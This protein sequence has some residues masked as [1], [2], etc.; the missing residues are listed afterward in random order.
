MSKQN[1]PQRL[2]AVVALLISACLATSASAS[3]AP[4]QRAPGSE[5]GKLVLVMDSSGSMAEKAAGGETKIVAAKK[6]LYTVIGGLPP[7]QPV[8][9]RVFG[10][11]VPSRSKPGACTDSQLKVPVGTGNHARLVAALGAYKPFGETPIGYALQQAG[12]DVGSAGRRSILLVSDGE[13]TCKPD[14]CT[15]ARELAKQGIDLE[16]DV[17]GLDVNSAARSKLQCIAHAGH[18]VYYDVDNSKDLVKSVEKVATRAARPYEEIGK[19]VNGGNTSITPAPIGNGDWLDH[20]NGHE[21]RYYK[22]TRTRKNSTVHFSAVIRSPDGDPSNTI[23]LST[24]DGQQCDASAGLTQEPYQL[25]STAV[26]AGPLDAVGDVV[27]PDDPCLTADTML[28][29]VHSSEEMAGVPIEIRVLELPEVRNIDALPEPVKKP[30]WTAPPMSSTP[31]QVRGGTSFNDA[32]TLTPGSYTDDIV[33]GETLTYRVHLDWGQQINAKATFAELDDA[34]R[35]AAFG[36]PLARIEAFSP[37]RVPASS[38][39]GGDDNAQAAFFGH[40]GTHLATTSG[41]VNFRNS[42]ASDNGIAG[43]DVDGTYTVVVFLSKE[44]S[45]QSVPVPFQLDLSV[46]GAKS[47]VPDFATAPTPP[48]GQPS[49]APPPSSTATPSSR[50]SASPL[51]STGASDDGGFPTGPVLGGLGALALLAAAGLVWQ[52]RS[53]TVPG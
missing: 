25:L 49:T 37:A 42:G 22:I 9:L 52:R 18:G 40:S 7:T 48:Q 26:L 16:I 51:A 12:K 24:A 6:A 41:P 27:S 3:T 23:S 46:L 5:T 1:F 47:G 11:T 17:V 8:G 50:P 28:A 38:E 43:A 13:P 19:P 4:P 33:Q 31:K 39:E 32:P 45:G 20:T 44:P 2:A 35:G 53:G 29:K 34:H 10:A 30:I 15:V 14:P 36:T 21:D